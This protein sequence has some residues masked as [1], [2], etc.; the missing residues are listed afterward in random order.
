MYATVNYMRESLL[1]EIREIDDLKS[2]LQELR[3]VIPNSFELYSAIEN[4]LKAEIA[5]NGWIDSDI[6]ERSIVDSRTPYSIN[7]KVL[8]A[9]L[10]AFPGPFDVMYSLLRGGCDIEGAA[11]QIIKGS[12]GD[13][14]NINISD[15]KRSLLSIKTE[16]NK[17]DEGIQKYILEGVATDLI[18]YISKNKQ[19]DYNRVIA[20]AFT[21]KLSNDEHIKPILDYIPSVFKALPV[22]IQAKM[23]VSSLNKFDSNEAFLK[24]L[25]GDAGIV[26]IKLGQILSEDPN[27]PD[28]YRSV[29]SSLRDTNEACSISDFWNLIPI[30]MRKDIQ[31]LGKCMGVGSVKQIHIAKM[32]DGSLKAVALIRKGAEDDAV[33]TLKALSEIDFMEPIV[34]RI[35]KLVFNEMDLLL[36]YEAFNKLKHSPYGREPYISIPNVGNISLRCLIRDFGNGSTLAKIYDSKLY[37]GEQLENISK[38]LQSLHRCAIDAAFNR[39]FIMSDLHLGNISFDSDTNKLTIFDPAQN[40]SLTN[41]QTTALLWTIVA[42]SDESRA[43]KFKNIVVDHLFR[44]S[45]TGEDGIKKI[46]KA[47]DSSS[48]VKNPKYRFTKLLAC[49]EQE[50]IILPNGF[51]ACAKMLDTLSSQEELLGMPDIVRDEISKLLIGRMSMYEK[52]RVVVNF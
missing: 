29:F 18:E 51:F 45:L 43:V 20:E 26:A 42:L 9:A 32:K 17:L 38:L 35:R 50:G 25:M 40:E 8:R 33:A 21:S 37:G 22:Y 47:Y 19:G 41:Q 15:L 36:E 39:G 30:S 28:T 16:F 1:A 10:T 7:V 12:D 31:S 3:N 27:V 23:F 34:G 44:I 52:V 49:C 6:L 46:S 24:S 14:E 13:R 11:D 4:E 5:K 2:R 48:T